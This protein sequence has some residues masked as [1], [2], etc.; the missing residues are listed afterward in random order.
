LA[1]K[2]WEKSNGASIR[3]IASKYAICYETLRKRTKGAISK[4]EASQAMQLLSA[5]EEESL[6]GW[7]KQLGEW[8][9]PPRVLQLRKMATEILAA[10]GYKEELG[11]HWTD[12]FFQRH[13]ELKAKFYRGLDRQRALA[14]DLDIIST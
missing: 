8:G 3:H 1:V 7:I 11:V 9:W 10:K 14:S 13:P 2:A 5:G 12:R 4:V 6:V